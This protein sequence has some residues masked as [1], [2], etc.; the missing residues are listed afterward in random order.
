MYKKIGIIFSCFILLA[1][2]SQ[3]VF[4][5]NMEEIMPKSGTVNAVKESEAYIVIDKKTNEVMLSKN[6]NLLWTPASL[7][8]LMTAMVFLDSKTMLSKKVAMKKE[9]E[10]GG[11][12]LYTKTGVQYKAS[13]LFHASLIA[14]NNNAT[15][16]LARSTGYSREKFVGLMNK[17]AAELG[18]GQTKFFEPTGI[19]P[20]NLTTASDFAKIINAA[21][22]DPY[23]GQVVKKNAYSF[24]A[25][26][27]KTYKHNLVTT[28]K[29]LGDG[30]VG[31]LGGKTGY[32]EESK[33]NFATITKDGF[34][35]EYI[36]V[37]LGAENSAAQFGQVKK[38]AYDAMAKRIFGF[39]AV[40]GTST[41]VS[42]K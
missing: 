7:T 30:Q 11:S 34:G 35:N 41:S 29:L 31:A 25:V 9:D 38:L 24:T 18:A 22:A 17:K 37:V 40:L 27:S 4:A 5:L 21:F 28:N 23:I 12:R 1:F 20:K 14:S 26:N 13:D 15:N 42:N 6:E 10:V 39:S 3:S 32:L 16:A 8:K 19:D 2:S 36:I 33:Y